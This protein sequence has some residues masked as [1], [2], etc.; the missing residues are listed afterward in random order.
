MIIWVYRHVFYLSKS[1][2]LI[3]SLNG[4]PIKQYTI[5]FQMYFWKNKENMPYYFFPNFHFKIWLIEHVLKF[6][7][8]FF[9]KFL[10]TVQVNTLNVSNHI[11]NLYRVDCFN[12]STRINPCKARAITLLVHLNWS[13]V[14]VWA[15]Y[16]FKGFFLKLSIVWISSNII[17][18]LLYPISLKIM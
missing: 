16:L 6:F 14:V 3:L 8:I 12:T 2:K 18:T 5:V 15:F 17:Y 9:R 11:K 10:K 1:E 7:P 4:K 13:G